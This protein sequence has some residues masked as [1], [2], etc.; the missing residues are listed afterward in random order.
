MI[1]RW[2]IA[3][4]GWEDNKEKR[5]Y[6]GYAVGKNLRPSMASIVL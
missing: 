5:I 3:M 4:I 2:T 6:D 1:D